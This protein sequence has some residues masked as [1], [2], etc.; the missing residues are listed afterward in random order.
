M[1]LYGQCTC[2]SMWIISWLQFVLTS[3][4]TADLVLFVHANLVLVLRSFSDD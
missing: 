2:I 3:F 1:S 4:S